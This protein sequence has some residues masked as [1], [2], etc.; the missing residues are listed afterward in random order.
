MN[1]SVKWCQHG[2]SLL[3][4]LHK[5]RANIYDYHTSWPFFP[6][7]LHALRGLSYPKDINKVSHLRVFSY[8]LSGAEPEGEATTFAAR[9][10]PWIQATMTAFGHGVRRPENERLIAWVN[11]V[12]AGVVSG[13]KLVFT[14]EQVTQLLH[15][16]PRTGVAV[17]LLPNRASDL[18]ASPKCLGS[19]VCVFFFGVRF[20]GIV[21]LVRFLL[22]VVSFHFDQQGRMKRMSVMKMM[23][24]DQKTR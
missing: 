9:N 13:K 1:T 6:L 8:K 15:S 14:I 2:M 20:L 24:K 18:R 22:K 21:F 19:T 10:E 5:D 7:L 17:I 23:M 12:T 3:P 4:R 16:F 11:Y